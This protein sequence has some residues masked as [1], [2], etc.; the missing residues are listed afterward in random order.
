MRE[1]VRDAL[2]DVLESRKTKGLH[3]S[4]EKVLKDLI[5]KGICDD[6]VKKAAFNAT[7]EIFGIT[8]E[9]LQKILEKNR[10]VIDVF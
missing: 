3:P 5:E 6:T 7:K 9:D 1:S 4:L 2:K 8:D 10:R